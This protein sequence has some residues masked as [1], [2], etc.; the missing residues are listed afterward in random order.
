MYN[1][2]NKIKKNFILINGDTF[3]NIDFNKILNK[4]LGNSIIKMCLVHKNK[5]FNNKIFTNIH[6]NKNKKIFFLNKKSSIMNGGIY[7]VSKII[8]K[9]VKNKKLSLENDIISNLIHQNKVSGEFFNKEF[10]DIGSKK[11]FYLKKCKI[12]KEQMSIFR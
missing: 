9:Y 6:L 2:R 12:N 3:F 4:S 8:F 5:T 10:I 7:L 1:L 11:L